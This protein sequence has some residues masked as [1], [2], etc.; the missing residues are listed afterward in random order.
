MFI[1]IFIGFVILFNQVF[2]LKNSSS[3]SFIQTSS[4]LF[5]MLLMNFNINDFY[6]DN[7]VLGPIYFSLFILFVVLISMNM[8]IS[9]IIDHFRIVRNN[10][11]LKQ[12]HDYQIYHF[13][14]KKFLR[15]IGFYQQNQVDE[16]EDE[17]EKRKNAK[18]Y[19]SIEYFPQLIDH[20]MDVIYQVITTKIFLFLLQSI[21]IFSF[22]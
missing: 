7:E 21:S 15:L 1:I 3:P 12:N 20:L 17:E 13:M 22:N 14:K 11:Q 9:I 2:N 5:Q 8:F 19:N 6:Q 4:I 10:I 18:Y 16:Q